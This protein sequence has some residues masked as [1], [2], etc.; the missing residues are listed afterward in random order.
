MSKRN[1]I[2]KS[3]NKY[4]ETDKKFINAHASLKN[5]IYSISPR[6]R[7]FLVAVSGGPDS[8]AICSL[9]QIFK[10]NKELTFKFVHVNHNIRKNS[11]NE[12]L[13][14]KKF[15]SK[16]KIN[17]SILN[18]NK[19]IQNNIQGLSRTYRYNLLSNFCKKNKLKYILVGHHSD[20]QIETFFI[21]LSRGSG[22]RG[23][24]A[25]QYSSKLGKSVTVL[26]PFLDIRK[27]DLIYITNRTFKKYYTDP[28]NKNSKFLR[29]KIRNLI[30]IFEKNG[31]NHHQIIRSI[32]NLGST[33]KTLDQFIDHLDKEIVVTKRN[34]LIIKYKKFQEVNEEIKL[35]ILAR[36][37]KNVSKSYYPPRSKK[38][39]N[40]IDRLDKNKEKKH[41]LGGCSVS[42]QGANVYIKKLT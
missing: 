31:I 26:R 3:L 39:F 7:K 20:D 27:K 10:D 37:I 36:A 4:L 23:L 33:R 14:L 19:K 11:K 1:L 25:M 24:S 28:S 9:L 12:A 35:N 15:L 18:I 13:R 34:Y 32:K 42:K 29:T 2:V 17:L 21:R 40:L 30:K 38:I 22:V 5:I 41:T 6:K 16:F 8:L